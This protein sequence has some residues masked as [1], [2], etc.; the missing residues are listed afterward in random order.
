MYRLGG[1]STEASIVRVAGGVYSVESYD[2][3]K[4]LGGDQLNRIL[5]DFIA[6][7]FQR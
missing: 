6:A 3:C 1:A 7:E 5:A 2:Q 4:D